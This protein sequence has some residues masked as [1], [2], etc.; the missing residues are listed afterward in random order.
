M[1]IDEKEV[2][3]MKEL[4][5]ILSVIFSALW[6]IAETIPQ[7]FALKSLWNWFLR[8]LGLPSLGLLQVTGI[9]F[10][11]FTIELALIPKKIHKESP[12]TMEATPGKIV[13]EWRWCHFKT[14]I[15]DSA[16]MYIAGRII[17]HVIQSL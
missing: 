17:F 6:Q 8:P 14:T 1:F 2:S 9:L 11:C 3:K 5:A 10:F 13:W 4:L 16:T 15:M 12:S 7:A